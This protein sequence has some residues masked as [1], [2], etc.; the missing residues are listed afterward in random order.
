MVYKTVDNVLSTFAYLY[1]VLKLYLTA[2]STNFVQLDSFSCYLEKVALLDAY[3]HLSVAAKSSLSFRTYVRM[4]QIDYVTSVCGYKQA[5]IGYGKDAI[6]GFC[7]HARS[8]GLSQTE[9]ETAACLATQ[10]SP[11]T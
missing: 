10:L 2:L 5:C 8:P 9:S 6:S 7:K 4:E 1:Q 3:S 11:N